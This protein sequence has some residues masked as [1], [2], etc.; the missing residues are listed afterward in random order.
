[1]WW[2]RMKEEFLSYCS[3]G[4]SI[5]IMTNPYQQ[6]SSF[7][8]RED[9]FCWKE[10]KPFG[11]RKNENKPTADVRI[12]KQNAFTMT[13]VG[14][15]FLDKLKFW[16]TWSSTSSNQIRAMSYRGG[17]LKKLLL[18]FIYYVKA[19]QCIP[20]SICDHMKWMDS[21]TICSFVMLKFI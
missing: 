5:E 17:W 4:E 8:N 16:W 10:G 14:R 19:L 3:D 2:W 12:L 20:D 7:Y 11:D 18:W 6:L 15:T 13:V 21:K 9:E 1:M